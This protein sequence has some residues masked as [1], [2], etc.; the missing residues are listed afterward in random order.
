MEPA[1]PSRTTNLRFGASKK[2][3]YWKTII[4]WQVAF[5]SSGCYITVSLIPQVIKLD[6]HG[7]IPAAWDM[8]ALKFKIKLS[9]P[10]WT[11]RDIYHTL[12]GG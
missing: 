6:L 11:T 12:K 4:L 3:Y 1:T 5:S 2:Q 8:S 10:S 7:R 9:Q